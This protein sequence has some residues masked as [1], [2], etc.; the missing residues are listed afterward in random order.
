[1]KKV[2]LNI[3]LIIASFLSTQVSAEEQ[4][5]M[6]G[7]RTVI[8]E[9]KDLDKAIEWYTEVFG[10]EP[11]VN[12]SEYVGFNVRGFELGLMPK[13]EKSIV[14]NNV[15]SYWG[16]T[17]IDLEYRRVIRLGAKPNTPV[18]PVGGGIRLG[19]V[20]DPFGNVLG[21]IYNPL[22]KLGQY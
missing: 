15:L 13:H 17:D 21:L 19:T 5:T 6:L 11:Y 16:V 2:V 3:S 18:I 1:M 10:I 12:T 14:G 7:L 8:Y 22:F 4:S 9:A 20:I